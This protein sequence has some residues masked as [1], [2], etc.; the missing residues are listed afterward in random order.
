V[1]STLLLYLGMGVGLLTLLDMF[2]SNDQKAAI[3]R[4]SIAV[5][6][7][8]DNIKRLSFMNWFRRRVPRNLVPIVASFLVVIPFLGLDQM[9]LVLLY[10]AVGAIVARLLLELLLR[11]RTRRG[12]ILRASISL[13]VPAIP[14]VL[15]V[16]FI[17]SIDPD[18]DFVLVN[19]VIVTVLIL[20][21]W[22]AFAFWAIAM[23]PFVIALTAGIGL[24]VA[25][26][27]ARRIAEYPK[28]PVL[29]ASAIFTAAIAIF[30]IFGSAS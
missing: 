18:S 9:G 24:S 4:S 25:E 3:E 6:N 1:I 19:L 13:L 7:W 21:I 8:I 27:V 15:F 14:V 17:R 30:K 11:A 26:F 10:G 23:L 2:L 16:L 20:F 22:L 12:F 28:G 29:A 5:W